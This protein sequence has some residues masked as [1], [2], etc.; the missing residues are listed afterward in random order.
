MVDFHKGA[1][2]KWDSC[3]TILFNVADMMNEGWRNVC[4][5]VSVDGASRADVLGLTWMALVLTVTV[6]LTWNRS[7]K[8]LSHTCPSYMTSTYP[9]EN[10]YTHTCT[11]KHTL[12]AILQA[13]SSH[14]QDPPC[15]DQENSATTRWRSTVFCNKIITKIMISKEQHDEHDSYHLLY[16]PAQLHLF[17][18][19]LFFCS[20]SHVCLL[21]NKTTW[22]ETE[23]KKSIWILFWR[24]KISLVLTKMWKVE[25]A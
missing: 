9:H 24:V 22:F 6:E 19:F 8:T 25:L 17:F 3:L 23:K 21:I 20:L 2:A 11:R 18:L 1:F 12:S 13:F 10:T 5:S 15:V 16:S 7:S 4:V 14:Q